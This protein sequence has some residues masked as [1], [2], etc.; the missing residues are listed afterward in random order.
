MA[1]ATQPAI[2]AEQ[3]IAA[4]TRQLKEMPQAPDLWSQ[5]AGARLVRGGETYFEALTA[6]RARQVG[7]S[8]IA[9]DGLPFATPLRSWPGERGETSSVGWLT[10]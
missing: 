5:R 10:A 2:D 3:Q 8:G 1:S 6:S 9:V 4:L 7:S